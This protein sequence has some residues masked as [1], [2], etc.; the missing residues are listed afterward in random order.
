MDFR[1]AILNLTILLC[2]ISENGC[3]ARE[4][5]TVTLEVLM[6]VWLPHWEDLI[7]G[8]KLHLM[9]RPLTR[10]ESSWLDERVG[11]HPPYGAKNWTR[12]LDSWTKIGTRLVR[13]VEVHLCRLKNIHLAPVGSTGAQWTFLD[14]PEYSVQTRPLLDNL[15]TK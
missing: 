7:L 1:L 10:V 3:S 13:L 11:E 5:V 2:R 15:P 6:N 12:L 14:Q 9:G 8:S 4:Q